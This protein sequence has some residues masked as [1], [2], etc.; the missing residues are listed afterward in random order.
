M[1]ILYITQTFPPEPGPTQR[2]LKQ[3]ICLQELGHELTILTTMP[4]Y[5]LGRVFKEYRGK[6][7]IKEKIEGIDTIRVWS[8]PAPNK[9]VIHRIISQISF[10]IAALI[11]ALCLDKHDLII[12]SVPHIGTEASSVIAAFLKKC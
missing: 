4:Y 6:L 1:K 10:A 9:G 2:P 5:P 11:T 7:L 3:A 12:A 8:I